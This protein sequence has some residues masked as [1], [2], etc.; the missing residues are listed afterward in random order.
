MAPTRDVSVNGP[1][2]RPRRVAGVGLPRR[3]ASPARAEVVRPGTT[4][5]QETEAATVGRPYTPA[6]QGRPGG[7]ARPTVRPVPGV[8]RDVQREPPAVDDWGLVHDAV[9]LQCRKRPVGT[10]ARSPVGTELP[11]R[12]QGSLRRIH[13]DTGPP[14]SPGVTLF[15]LGPC[16]VPRLRPTRASGAP[17][18]EWTDRVSRPPLQSPPAPMEPETAR[19]E[20]AHGVATLAL[21]CTVGD[22]RQPR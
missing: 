17:G 16:P 12:T 11:R 9:H 3:D 20:T 6:P 22:D 19:L 4:T 13:T 8:G 21:H 18:W 5:A 15:P 1:Q 2:G 10:W 14:K 7:P